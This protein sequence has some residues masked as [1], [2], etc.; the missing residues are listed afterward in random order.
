[1]NTFC[2]LLLCKC[3]VAMACI[4]Y[5]KILRCTSWHG[6]M[7][8]L[9]LLLASL[10]LVVSISTISISALKRTHGISTQYAHSLAPGIVFSAPLIQSDLPSIYTRDGH[11]LISVNSLHSPLPFTY[12]RVPYVPQFADKPCATIGTTYKSFCVFHNSSLVVD[13]FIHSD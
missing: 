10:A 7:Q 13:G 2:H 8:K 3:N 11:L 12:V 4:I 1:M 6:E 5:K 9:V